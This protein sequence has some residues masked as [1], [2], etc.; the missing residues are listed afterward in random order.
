MAEGQIQIGKIQDYTY[1]MF[2]KP[3]AAELREFQH[4]LIKS[5]G[6]C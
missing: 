6:N 3:I 5:M 1:T 4:L 2:L